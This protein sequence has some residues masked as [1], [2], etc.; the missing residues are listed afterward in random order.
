M[1]CIRKAAGIVLV[2]FVAVGLA[3]SGAA[4]RAFHA[5]HQGSPHQGCQLC[6]LGGT[7]PAPP[8]RPQNPSRLLREWNPL[9]L[10]SPS[11]KA[12]LFRLRSRAPPSR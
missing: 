1:E 7:P 12:P 11:E 4:H 8:A 2:L 6:I 9:P 10:P 3:A 5:H